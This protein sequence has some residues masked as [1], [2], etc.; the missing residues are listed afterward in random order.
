MDARDA[1][2]AIEQVS[3]EHVSTPQVS[4]EHW[5]ADTGEALLHRLNAPE[6]MTFLGGP[7]TDEKVA[8]RHRR[9]LEGTRTGASTM[10]RVVVQGHPEGVAAIGYWPVI[11]QDQAVYESG[12]TV[13]S[14]WHG[15]GIATAALRLVL[16]HAASAGD[17]RMLH[18]MPRIDNAASNAV[19]RK[20]GLSLIGRASS[21]YPRGIPITVNDWAIDLGRSG[22]R[23]INP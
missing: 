20:A 8:S 14:G 2:A 22:T 5:D 9:Y 16:R 1:G 12:W 21:E 3:V 4:L 10:F 23:P 19:C 13:Q 18:A 17:R 6:L 15:R 11:W 7:E